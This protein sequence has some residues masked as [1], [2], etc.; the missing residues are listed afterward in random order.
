MCFITLCADL[1]YRLVQA[2]E[3][4]TIYISKALALVV[5]ERYYGHE[6]VVESILQL[7]AKSR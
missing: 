2:N 5:H 4:K 7:L 3:M 6:A 1:G